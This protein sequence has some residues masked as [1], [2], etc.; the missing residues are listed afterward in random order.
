MVFIPKAKFSL[1][2]HAISSLTFFFP[3]A[4]YFS[5]NLSVL[6]YYS[7]P[8]RRIK[9]KIDRQQFIVKIRLAFVRPAS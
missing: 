3:S 8:K 7:K 5:V 2:A 6:F 1:V 4:Y 9:E